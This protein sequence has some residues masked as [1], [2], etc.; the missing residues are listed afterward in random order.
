MDVLGRPMLAHQLERVSR[1]QELDI[2]VVATSCDIGD[3]IL[4][5][6]CSSMGVPC[7]RGSE[8]DVLERYLHAARHYR[9]D[10]VVRMTA[11]CPLIDPQVI[12]RV[13]SALVESA[14]E[15]DYAANILE[16][17]FPRGLD[18]EAFFMDTLER[19][20]RRAT[21]AAAREHVTHHL[22]RERPDLYSTVSVRDVEDHSMYRW[23]VDVPED[24]ALIRTIYG[25]FRHGR[26]AYHEA[27]DALR[28]HPQWATINA[29]VRQKVF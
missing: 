14:S 17:T 13:V 8:H 21:S 26:F 20:A 3:D 2:V 6:F 15:V 16:R 4:G 10:V 25:H 11:D 27:L 22:L 18:V 28:S 24:L 7:F 1:S 9:A 23:T 19:V 12:D 29:G 5:A